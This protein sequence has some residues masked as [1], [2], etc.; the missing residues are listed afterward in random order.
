MIARIATLLASA[1]LGTAATPQDC[2]QCHREARVFGESAMARALVPAAESAILKSNPKLTAKLG[3]Y[4]YEIAESTLVVRDGKETLRASL[5]WAFGDGKVG[6]TYLYRVNGAW[7]ESRVSYFT[8]IA[9]LDITLGQQN[10]TPRN[11]AEAAGR[12]AAP[13]E[14]TK[15]FDC[16]ATG[17]RK[18]QITPGV[19]CDRCHAGAEVHLRSGAPM[20]KLSALTTEELS[21]FCGE[22]HRTWSQVAENGP[23]GI[24]NIRF[25]PY[26]LAGA[27]CYN[28]ADSRIKCTACHDPHRLL[29]TRLE[30]YDA[31]C[32]ACHSASGG[33]PACRAG[34]RVCAGCH[35]PK[36]DLPGAHHKFTDH[37]IRI[38][39]AGEAYPD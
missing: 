24:Q 29:E 10:I 8:V 3:Q 12:L 27:K 31:K 17:A 26:R 13:A 7:Y 30:A 15:C 19:L 28:A 35:M 2:A 21:D 33:A 22:C 25:Q 34:T 9:G 39:K 38:A 18:Q 32:A 37:R 6:Q 14:A 36:L 16:H 4:S 1:V 11:L 23:R 20:K 5:E